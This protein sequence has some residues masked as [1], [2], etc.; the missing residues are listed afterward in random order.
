MKIRI[1]EACPLTF[2]WVSRKIENFWRRLGLKD[3]VLCYTPEFK[4][5]QRY[6]SIPPSMQVRQFQQVGQFGGNIYKYS[7]IHS[8]DGR[9]ESTVLMQS[10]VLMEPTISVEIDISDNSDGTSNKIDNSNEIHSSD[11][12]HNYDKFDNSDNLMDFTI[13]RELTQF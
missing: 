2:T 3:H 7:G 5:N 12:V 6:Y 1:L 9:F 8:S 13:P 11:E 10:T 4:V